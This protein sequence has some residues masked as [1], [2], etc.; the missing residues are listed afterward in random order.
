MSWPFY[1][2]TVVFFTLLLGVFLAVAHSVLMGVR[3]NYLRYY[4]KAN[5]QWTGSEA[6]LK[7][8]RTPFFKLILL[9][10][11]FAWL[12]VHFLISP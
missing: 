7:R 4:Q 5:L 9:A 8:G 6:R 3:D 2:S 12:V 1:V 11:L 10:F